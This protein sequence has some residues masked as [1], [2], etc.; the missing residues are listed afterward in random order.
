LHMTQTYGAHGTAFLWD[1]MAFWVGSFLVLVLWIWLLRETFK[2]A[3]LLGKTRKLLV[4]KYE[5]AYGQ[6]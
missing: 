2:S 1:S 3:E 6:S 4:E 5:T